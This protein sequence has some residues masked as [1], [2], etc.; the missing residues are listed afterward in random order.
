M[1]R[2]LSPSGVTN[3][4]AIKVCAAD[5]WIDERW[6]YVTGTLSRLS[7]ITARYAVR[8]TYTHAYGYGMHGMSDYCGFAPYTQISRPFFLC[9]L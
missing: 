1:T 6:E 8:G 2:P 4:G 5:G 9:W 7:P 3:G